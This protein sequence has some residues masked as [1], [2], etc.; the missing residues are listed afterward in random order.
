[1]AEEKAGPADKKPALS[2][3]IMQMKFMQRGKDRAVAQEA[4]KEQV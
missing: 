2:G 4:V 1:M 3:R